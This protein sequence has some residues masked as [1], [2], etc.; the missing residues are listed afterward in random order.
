M[1]ENEMNRTADLPGADADA[2]ASSEAAPHSEFYQAPVS[3]PGKRPNAPIRRRTGTLTLGLALILVGG[4]ILGY[5]F[6]P[7]FDLFAAAKL[8]PLLLVLMGLEILIGSFLKG[9][10]YRVN[11]GSVLLCLI[12]VG[13]S[14]CAAVIPMFWDYYGPEEEQREAQITSELSSTCYDQL[15]NSGVTDLDSYLANNYTQAEHLNE[16]T[17]AD[18]L[19]VNVDL[20]GEYA[21][22]AAF[23][24]ACQP[25]LSVLTQAIPSAARQSVQLEGANTLDGQPDYSV[26]L[27]GIYQMT[28]DLDTLTSLV[29][30]SDSEEAD[31]L[32]QREQEL[33]E[34]QASLEEWENRLANDSESADDEALQAASLRKAY[35]A[36]QQLV[37][38]GL[39]DDEK[40]ETARRYL[41]ETY[42]ELPEA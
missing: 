12:L 31:A 32:A 22:A 28:A 38:S 13:C 6:V 39:L 19:C 11:F 30:A 17:A 33:N 36:V 2:A 21:D 9:D 40:A 37:D 41:Y 29:T 27:S 4:C 24:R 23:A 8:S 34:R 3:N 25:V 26:S 5:C 16:L 10:E 7:G 35:E 42:G 1:N 14:L 15:K 20:R 18:H